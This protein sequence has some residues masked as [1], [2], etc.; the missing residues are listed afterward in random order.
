MLANLMLRVYYCRAYHIVNADADKNKR[1]D[2]SQGR[3]RNACGSS[4]Q[5]RETIN[6]ELHSERRQGRWKRGLSSGVLR[7]G[8][9]R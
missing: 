6:V 3:E 1:Q 7:F 9:C 4:E 2:L 8:A 5:Q